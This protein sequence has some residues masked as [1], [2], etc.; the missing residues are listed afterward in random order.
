[1]TTLAMVSGQLQVAAG[2]VA[3]GVVGERALPAD[4]RDPHEQPGGDDIQTQRQDGWGNAHDTHSFPNEIRRQRRFDLTRGDTYFNLNTASPENL[5]PS[6]SIAR[7][8]IDDPDK[9]ATHASGHQR[10]RA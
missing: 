10:L 4:A 3:M 9:H 1:M 8:R 7:M 6:A 2:E 5:N